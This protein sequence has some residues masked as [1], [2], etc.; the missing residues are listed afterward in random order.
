MKMRHLHGMIRI[1]LKFDP[2]IYNVA[3]DEHPASGR[4]WRALERPVFILDT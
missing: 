1:S 3:A 4:T 2:L